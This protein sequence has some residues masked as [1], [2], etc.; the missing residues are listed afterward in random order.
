MDPNYSAQDV[1][2]SVGSVMGKTFRTIFKNPLLFLGLAA[3]PAI[4]LGVASFMLFL[5]SVEASN[6]GKALNVPL[7][8]L[9]VIIQG[10]IAYAA[11]ESFMGNR[12]TMGSALSRAAS[13][14][15][16]LILLMLSMSLCFCLSA[17]LF[18][19]P[20]IIL[21]CMWSVAIPSCVIEGLGVRG[22]LGRSRQLTKGYR[23]KVLALLSL[24]GILSFVTALLIIG[25]FGLITYIT[26]N[27]IPLINA[28]LGAWAFA[29]TMMSVMLGVLYCCLRSVK[30]GLVSAD[31]ANVFN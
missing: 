19:I 20:L 31:L 26:G 1:Q 5:P 6:V 8:I 11:F 21:T 9:G 23:W 30:E 2:F 13:R 24:A 12:V 4:F 22:S 25:V 3:I 10:A 29:N 15:W 14:T 28:G 18:F 7:G 27:G 16:R 17:L